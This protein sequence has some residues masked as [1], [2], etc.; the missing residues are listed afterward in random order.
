MPITVTDAAEI[1]AA[2][3]Q[4]SVLLWNLSC[5]LGFVARKL[6]S[7]IFPQTNCPILTAE[8]IIIHCLRGSDAQQRVFRLGHLVGRQ[9][10]LKTTLVFLEKGVRV[11]L[12]PG[13]C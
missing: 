5:L 7:E 4:N 1:W 6:P 12:V 10:L 3:G 13:L 2:R 9:E 8:L 11:Y